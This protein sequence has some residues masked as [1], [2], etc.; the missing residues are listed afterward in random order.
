MR[1]AVVFAFLAAAA[2]TDSTPIDTGDVVVTDDTAAPSPDDQKADANDLSTTQAKTVRFELDQVCGDTWCDGDFDFSFKK[3]VCH[4]GAGT[5]TITALIWP[6]QET[7]PIPVYWRSCKI[8]GL[9]RFE[10]LIDTAP[11]GYQSLHWDFYEKMTTCTMKIVSKL[12][13]AI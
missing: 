5:C 12:P 1:F 8:S 13:P 11:N 10:D 9:H 4:F 3:A 7:K 6:R 2:C